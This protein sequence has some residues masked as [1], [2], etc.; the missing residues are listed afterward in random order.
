VIRAR[1]VQVRYQRG[2]AL[3]VTGVGFDL[4]RGEGLLLTGGHGSGKSSVLR[5][6]L[7]LAGP[8]GD[9]TVLGG[10]PGD[11]AVLQRIGW[12]PQS[13]PFTYGIRAAE[14]ATMVARLKGHGPAE[15]AA[16]MEE[17]GFTATAKLAPLLEIEESRQLSL[18]CAIIGEPD[19]L[20][21]DD[22]WE[23]EETTGIIRRALDRGCAVLAAS[24]D[25]GGLPALLGAGI[26]LADG[27]PA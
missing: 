7:G 21:L 17:A 15:A 5:A 23:F 11:P 18:A 1:D 24:S 13:W 4:A 8:G 22:P 6:V 26:E 25:P 10:R 9:I 27:V 2:G 20:V 12:A 19:L 14:V 3:A 16:A